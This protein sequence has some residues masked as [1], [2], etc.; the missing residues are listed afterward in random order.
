VFTLTWLLPLLVM[1]VSYL[2]IFLIIYRRS[3]QFKL[4]TDHG[5]DK[6]STSNHG[7]IGRAKIQ[8][9]KVTGVLVLG[10]VLCWTPYNVMALW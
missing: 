6:M 9:V 7:I 3:Q 5:Q 8:T 4:T 10:F 2:T 1:L